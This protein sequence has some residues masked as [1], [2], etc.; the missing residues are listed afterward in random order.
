MESNLCN[1]SAVFFDFD[2]V[3]ADSVEVKTRA[4]A[5]LF[6][7]YGPDVEE[8]VVDHHRK[9]GGMTRIDKFHHYYQNFLKKPLTE[10]EL[11]R[12]CNK[13]SRLVVDEVVSAPEI[14]GAGECLKKMYGIVK[15]FVVSATPDDEIIEIM[16]SR[17]IDVYFEEILGSARSKSANIDYLLEKYGFSP[18]QCLFFGDAESDYRAATGFNVKFMGIVPNEQAPLLQIAPDICWACDFER[19][20]LENLW[21]VDECI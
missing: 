5:K 12:L 19:L 2:G 18:G 17:S 8:K 6:E 1:L 9:N 3:L 15:L 10:V 4:F 13:F 7:C 20:D 11:K 14:A 21:D 16:K